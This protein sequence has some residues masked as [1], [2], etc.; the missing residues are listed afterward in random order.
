M[1]WMDADEKEPNAAMV[2]MLGMMDTSGDGIEM[3]M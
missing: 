2:V 1:G 3:K